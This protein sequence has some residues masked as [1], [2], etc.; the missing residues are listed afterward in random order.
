MTVARSPRGKWMVDV[1]FRHPDGRVERVRQVSPV[2]TKAGAQRYELQLRTALLE[3]TYARTAA[4][5]VA[6]TPTFAE[7][8]KDYLT[9]SATNN[10]ARTHRE[11]VATFRRALLPFFGR[12][13]LDAIGFRDFERYKATRVAAGLHAKT[14]NDEC[15]L[16]VG[17]LRLAVKYKLIAAAPVFERLR[18]P[19]SA[20]DFLEFDEADRLVAI[21]DE[22]WRTMILVALR[23]GLR[24]GELR[25]LRW[26]DVDLVKRQLTVRQAADDKGAITPPKNGRPRTIPL[27]PAA[28]AAL[29]R[30]KHLRGPFVFCADDG[31]PFTQRQLERPIE[32]ACRR[33]GLRSVGWHTLR[34]TFASHLVMT[35]SSLKHVQELGGWQTLAMV[36]RYAHLAPDARRD[37]VAALDG[38]PAR[39]AGK[40]DEG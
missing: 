38:T 13:T 36:M 27:S 32:R 23:T 11:K 16:V 24:R 2:Q 14:I 21:P 9:Y 15:A 10:R 39:P 6:A 31:A 29:R 22:P 5:V 12:M 35:G 19:P 18:Q 8:A 26:Q 1:K 30:H 40:A 7:F 34:H 28:V 37:A 4:P 17:A 25:A 3:G 20:F 33:A